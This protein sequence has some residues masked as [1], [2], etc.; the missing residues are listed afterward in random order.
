MTA[1]PAYL[2]MGIVAIALIDVGVGYFMAI[3]AVKAFH[4]MN[5]CYSAIIVGV[6]ILSI[7]PSHRTHAPSSS[8]L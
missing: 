7:I 5:V 8:V 2:G 4:Y 3:V 1:I 6:V